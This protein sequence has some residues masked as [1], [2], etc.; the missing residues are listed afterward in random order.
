MSEFDLIG[1]LQQLICLP[2]AESVPGCGVGIGDDA[3]ILDIPPGHEL[4]V[5]TDTLVEGIHFPRDT[6]PEAIGHKALA[7]NLSDLAAM[8]AQPTF[9]FMALTLPAEDSAWLDAFA[10]GMARLASRFRVQLAGGDTTRGPLSITITALGV[11]EKGQALLRSGAQP[12]D[13]VVVSG[14]PGAAARALS[15][16]QEGREPEPSGR[17]AL[18]FPQPRIN[19][20]SALVKR[21]TSC[22]DL[23]DGLA[24]DLGHV[25]EQSGVGAELEL[26]RL[27]VPPGLE[28][29]AE[30]QRWR[31]QLA[32][33]DDYEL[34][35]TIPPDRAVE[36][37]QLSDSCGVALTS[38]GTIVTRT[39]LELITKDGGRFELASAGFRHFF[40]GEETLDQ[41]D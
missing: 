32:G 4:V 36:L 7:V 13:L 19:V 8:G 24:A 39:G 41:A 40:D 20:G 10:R 25:L 16:M 37:D 38:V 21:A 22:I 5:C 29:L 34:C 12:G 6:Q 28:N 3:A 23:S 33:G 15:A 1:R 18:E 9:F 26:D 11:V 30:E 2:D 27:P 35:F 17:M 14:A 31:L